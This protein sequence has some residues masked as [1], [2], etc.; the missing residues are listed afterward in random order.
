MGRGEQGKRE[1]GS[2]E[3]EGGEGDESHSYAFSYVIPS[4]AL[5]VALPVFF[6]EE[7]FPPLKN[8]F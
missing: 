2:G 4:R 8:T 5:S 7:Y 1:V 6:G 3:G